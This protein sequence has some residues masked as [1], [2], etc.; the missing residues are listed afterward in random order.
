MDYKE[1]KRKKDS[2]YNK[3]AE[4]FLKNHTIRLERKFCVPQNCPIWCDK[5][6]HDHGT[7]YLFTFIRSEK[8]IDILFWGSMNDREKGVS[9]VAYDLLACI[10]KYDPDTFENFC[11]EFGYDT[12]SRKAEKTYEAVK[13]EYAKV[14]FFFTAEEIEELQEIQ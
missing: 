4:D 10:T 12:D 14:S 3:T 7:N 9:P 1:A 5:K 2:P 6:K 13:E 8:R 11:R